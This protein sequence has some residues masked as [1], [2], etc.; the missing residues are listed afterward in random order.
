MKNAKYRNEIVYLPGGTDEFNG[1]GVDA[2][3][4]NQVGSPI[5]LVYGYRADGIYNTQAEAESAGLFWVDAKGFQHAFRAGDVKFVNVNNS[6][7]VIDDADRVVIGE[8]NPDFTGMFYNK[9]TYKKFT[10]DFIF[11]FS[12]GNDIYNALRAKTEAM[13]DFSN[14]S[15][16]VA[17]RWKVENQVSDVPRAEYGDP[18]GN[19]RFSDRWI[20]DG[21]YMRLKSLT[22]SYTPD[23]KLNFIKGVTFFVSANNLLTFSKY[24]GYDPEVSMSGNS[25]LQGIDAG[26]VPQFKSVFAGFRLGL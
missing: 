10:L 6:D 14:Q 8:P 19:S 13:I 1:F 11:T 3:I 21:S 26:M 17:N 20:E 23:L 5:G 25:Y 4:R 15:A 2:T 7:N 12:K 18:T 24:L 22:F 16:A 9:F